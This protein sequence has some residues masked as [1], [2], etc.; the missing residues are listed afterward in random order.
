M[1]QQPTPA[2]GAAH[3]HCCP[4]CR[5]SDAVQYDLKELYPVGG[6]TA[7]CSKEGGPILEISNTCWEAE[8]STPSVQ[9]PVV[10]EAWVTLNDGPDG[11][12]KDPVHQEECVPDLC[13]DEV[14]TKQLSTWAATALPHILEDVGTRDVWVK[15]S[16]LACKVRAW[17]AAVLQTQLGSS[18]GLLC[19]W[20]LEMGSGR[21][22]SSYLVC[23][24][25]PAA[26][27]LLAQHSLAVRKP[28]R[29]CR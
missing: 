13:S 3:I 19:H 15:H 26:I 9:G 21:G 12:V 6:L 22:G 20:R 24:C 17:P 1:A 28:G 14:T 7:R 16:V 8:D 11:Q 23:C 4:T 27:V 2:V 29:C 18:A 25:P 10:V 5:Q